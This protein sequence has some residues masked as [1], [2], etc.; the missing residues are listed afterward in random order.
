MPPHS[1]IILMSTLK[2]F[3]KGKIFNGAISK[4]VHNV[5]VYMCAKFDAFVIKCTITLLHVCCLIMSQIVVYMNSMKTVLP[6]IH[7]SATYC[8]IHEF[9]ARACILVA[10]SIHFEPEVDNEI[11]DQLAYINCA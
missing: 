5:I 9:P 10:K 2:R 8:N 11:H 6:S 3:A 1:L 7:V 4:F